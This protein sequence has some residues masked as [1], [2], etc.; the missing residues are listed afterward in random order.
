[1]VKNIVEAI[2]K[3][4]TLTSGEIRVHLKYFCGKDVLREAKDQFYKLRMDRTKHHNGVLILVALRSRRFA[5]YG[6]EAIHRKVGD[7]FWNETRDKIASYFSEGRIEPG[8]V[9]GVESVG[10]QMRKHFP[11]DRND[12]NELSNEV[13][14]G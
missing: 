13:T 4:E 10:E 8:I 3:A 7:F 9:A 5:L 14:E 12:S 11:S 2:Q 1:M 6:D